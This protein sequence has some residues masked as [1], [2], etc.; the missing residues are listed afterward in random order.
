M[1]LVELLM[2]PDAVGILLC[3]GFLKVSRFISISSL[4]GSSSSSSD[5]YTF[6]CSVFN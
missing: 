6:D 3:P 4:I 5:Y 2:S 1:S